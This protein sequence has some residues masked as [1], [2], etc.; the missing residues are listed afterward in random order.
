MNI[1]FN[2]NTNTYLNTTIIKL[3]NDILTLS[4]DNIFG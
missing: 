2:I 4:I 3:H 1:N